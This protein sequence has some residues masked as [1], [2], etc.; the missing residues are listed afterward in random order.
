MLRINFFIATIRTQYSFLLASA[1][2]ASHV[3]HMFD[4]ALPLGGVIAIP[5][6]GHIIDSFSSLAVLAFLVSAASVI[7]ILGLIPN[8]MAAALANVALLVVYRPF[9]YTAVGDYAVKVFGFDTFGTVYGSLMCIA[10]LG[11]FL[12][13]GL[14]FAYQR[15]CGGNPFLVNFALFALGLM[16]GVALVW[17]VWSVLRRRR[18]I[19]GDL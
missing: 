18:R 5:F 13:S 1:G 12:Q 8:S 7:G 9:F 15:V 17:F 16:A 6:V 10:G 19:T 3:N 14:D 4:A 2:V 11:N